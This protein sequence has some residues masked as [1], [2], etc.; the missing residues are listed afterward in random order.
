[1]VRNLPLRLSLGRAHRWRKRGG[2]ELAL[3]GRPLSL[4]RILLAL[5]CL[6]TA[7]L[8]AERLRICLLRAVVRK[9]LLK[10]L[11]LAFRGSLAT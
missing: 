8:C 10:A 5:N 7:P 2:S 11:W 3:L 1:M 9:R 4:S 6:N